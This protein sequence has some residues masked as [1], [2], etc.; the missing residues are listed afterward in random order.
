MGHHKHRRA[1]SSQASQQRGELLLEESI[2]SLGRLIEQ[3]QPRLVQQH[4][5]QRRPLHLA[6]GQVEG[7]SVKQ[8]HNV[9]QRRHFPHRRRALLCREAATVQHLFQISPNGLLHHKVQRILRKHSHPAAEQLGPL[10]I[11]QPSPEHGDLPAIGPRNAA[12]GA[13]H[14][15]L[16][17][18]V[19]AHHR[20]QRPL[21][22]GQRRPPQHIGAIALIAEP[23]IPQLHRRPRGRRVASLPRRKRPPMR[24]KS[25]HLVR[26][27]APPLPH[28][29]GSSNL[30]SH[31]LFNYGR[32]G[33]PQW[34]GGP[35]AV[36]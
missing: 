13:Q 22:H 11:L 17:R 30:Q 14:R 16:P 24:R 8:R 21:R 3:Q 5:G 10:P 2:E 20:E 35:R 4:L 1:P 6:T 26:Q 33:P 15:R 12:D 32:V 34:G 18:A 29:E 28:R 31:S 9:C 36:H 27:P 19:A 23:H 7:M 25:R